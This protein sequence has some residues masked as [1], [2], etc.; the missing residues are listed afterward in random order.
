M[1]LYFANIF[2]G[3]LKITF[4]L[5]LEM[6]RGTLFLNR[7]IIQVK[8]SKLMGENSKLKQKTHRKTGGFG[9]TRNIGCRNL[10]KKDGIESP[11]FGSVKTSVHQLF[12]HVL[13]TV[14]LVQDTCQCPHSCVVPES[15]CF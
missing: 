8:N 5:L 3:M 7:A 13:G 10:V 4:L 2:L 9:K 11:I 14:G 1:N 12:L 15:M 6:Y